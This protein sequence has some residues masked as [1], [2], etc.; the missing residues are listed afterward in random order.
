MF[1]NNAL[2]L[3]NQLRRLVADST[4]EHIYNN[5]TIVFHRWVGGDTHYVSVFATFLSR[6]SMGHEKVLF[7]C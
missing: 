7:G 2:D 6:N 5:V 1:C 3:L 4:R